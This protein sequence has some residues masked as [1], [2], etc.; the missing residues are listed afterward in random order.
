[1]VQ[2]VRELAD[3]Y[4]AKTAVVTTDAITGATPSG[5]LCH[6]KNR[7]NTS[8]L[9]TEINRLIAEQKIEYCIGNAGDDLTV[10]TRKALNKIADS[11]A[12]FFIMVEGAHIDKQS[13]SNNY[14]GVVYMTKRFN[15]SIAYAIE[16][17]MCHPDT[18]LIITADHETGGLTYRSQEYNFT[19]TTHTNADVPVY[20]FGAGVEPLHDTVTD[21]TEIAK[22]IAKAFGGENFGQ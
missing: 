2:N 13:H 14:D 8:Q 15:D 11:D 20:A 19:T 4:G 17:V 22:F 5:F 16:F 7:N 12:P 6:N 9:Q 21:N 10:H 3:A 18:A 1:M